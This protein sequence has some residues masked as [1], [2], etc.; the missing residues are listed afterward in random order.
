MVE[1]IC[2][3]CKKKIQI[4]DEDLINAG[5][6]QIIYEVEKLLESMKK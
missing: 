5:R 2:Y 3:D 1:I 4:D 6:R